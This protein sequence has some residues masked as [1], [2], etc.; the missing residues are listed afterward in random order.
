MDRW[1]G[2]L[3]TRWVGGERGGFKNCQRCGARSLCHLDNVPVC[4]CP[5]YW[6]HHFG[7]WRLAFSIPQAHVSVFDWEGG[8]FHRKGL[9]VCVCVRA[10]VCVCLEAFSHSVRTA[11]ITELLRC[12][13]R[14]HA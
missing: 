13:S 7:G 1:I 5:T 9:F 4:K 8:S 14:D 2:W 11:P 12:L 10:R 3:S 6:H